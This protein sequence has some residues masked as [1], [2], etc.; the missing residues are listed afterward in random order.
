M[1]IFSNRQIPKCPKTDHVILPGTAP[2]TARLWTGSRIRA[3]AGGYLDF[4]KKFKLEQR[5][6][7]CGDQGGEPRVN[8]GQEV[9]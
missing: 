8:R 1:N 7:I 2:W 4:S 5:R 6:R 9:D 3:G